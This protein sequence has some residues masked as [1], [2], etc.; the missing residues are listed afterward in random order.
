MSTENLKKKNLDSRQ[1]Y[2]PIHKRKE[3]VEKNITKTSSTAEGCNQQPK[4]NTN[5]RRKGRGQFKAPD[6]T[7]T[8]TNTQTSPNIDNE[9][10][11]NDSTKDNFQEEDEDINKIT[12]M[13]KGTS[14]NEESSRKETRRPRTT[15]AVARRL[16]GHALGIK[17]TK[18]PEQKQVDDAL[19]RTTRERRQ[20]EKECMND[21]K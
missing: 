3:I 1:V 2:I 14:L 21:K 17:M 18:T 20:Q 9:A 10:E 6:I 12:S 19:L 13:M 4:Q 7:H 11:S 16:I 8:C 5:I 15:D